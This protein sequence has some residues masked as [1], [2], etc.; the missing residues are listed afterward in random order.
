MA[1]L[2]LC[3]FI[4]GRGSNLQSLIDACTDKDYPAQIVLVI[5]NVDG[6]LGLERAKAAGIQ[7]LVFERKNY[8]NSK[9][10]DAAMNEVRNPG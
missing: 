5:S 8:K 7:T 3:V 10:L 2:K 4:S 9:S 1:K 6:V